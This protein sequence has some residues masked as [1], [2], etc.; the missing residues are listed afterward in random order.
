[1]QGSSGKQLLDSG[2][3]WVRTEDAVQKTAT[4]VLGTSAAKVA[5]IRKARQVEHGLELHR[6]AY[7]SKPA[8]VGELIGL[9][10]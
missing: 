4:K 9:G 1:V 8:K 6:F 10:A 2:S 5:N 3:Q 7:E